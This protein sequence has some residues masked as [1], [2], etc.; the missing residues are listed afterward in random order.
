M[1]QDA[2]AGSR[3]ASCAF[4]LLSQE[5]T[6]SSPRGQASWQRP[7]SPAAPQAPRRR[8]PA[9]WLAVII[10]TVVA[11]AAAEHT[12]H[13][14]SIVSSIQEFLL[15]YTGVFALVG[16]TAAVGVG[17][18]ATDRIVMRP[19]SRVVAQSVHRGVS[20]GALAAL[21]AHIALEITAHRAGVMDAVVP[22]VSRYRTLYTGLGTLAADL[23]LLIVVTGFVRGRFAGKWPWAWR[24]IH[25]TAYAAWPLS[26]VHGLLGG[27]A[28]KPY[29]DWSYGGCLALVAIA[30]AVRYV[31]TVRSHDEKLSHPVPDRLS[32][33]AEGLIP[34]A[35]VT[36]APLGAA[37]PSQ[38]ALPASPAARPAPPPG[39]RAPAEYAQA[40][41]SQAQELQRQ[42]RQAQQRQ[43]RLMEQSYPVPRWAPD[44]SGP[45]DTR[46]WSIDNDMTDPHGWAAQAADQGGA[47]GWPDAQDL[48]DAHGWTDT[49][50]PAGGLGTGAGGPR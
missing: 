43:E 46:E 19:G 40:R 49:L 50:G 17:V 28:A 30:L 1:T 6:L 47:Y 32:V 45:A 21:V 8:W 42:Q 12:S 27:R 14:R 2:S 18:L 3:R 22:F 7:P 13:G 10:V 36:M 23:F 31:A 41:Y 11:V 20:L 39:P 25:A 29:V 37:P 38:R 26:V 9:I 15:T 35:R 24:L 16:L 4:P 44:G 5:A 34:G 48:A 33:P